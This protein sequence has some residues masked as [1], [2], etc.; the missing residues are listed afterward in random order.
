M[1]YN[2]ILLGLILFGRWTYAAG[3]NEEHTEKIIS[4]I[5]T[6][7]EGILADPGDMLSDSFVFLTFWDFDGTIIEGDCSEGMMDDDTLIYK[8]IAQ[9]AIEAGYSKIYPPQGGTDK[10]FKDYYEMNDIGGWLGLP[11]LPQMLRGTL[12]SDIHTLSEKHFDTVLSR[13]Y[14]ESSIQIMKAMEDNK[15]ECHIISA[16]PD[17]FVDAA[18]PTLGLPV[19]RFNGIKLVIENERLTERL[20]YPITWSDGKTGILI[21]I[22]EE[23]K[24]RHP[25]KQVFVLGA[26]GNSYGTDGPFMRYVATQKLPEG[27]PLAI[28]INGGEPPEAYRGLFTQVQQSETVGAAKSD[29]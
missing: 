13:Y 2:L 24:Q 25:G 17:V 20:V 27:K 11:F 29:K 1:K 21:S 18:A 16:S 4:D 6:T 9:V 23:T 14:F 22:V 8:G 28:M 15:V 3:G 12:V 10:F 19:E 7:K 5:L 26:F